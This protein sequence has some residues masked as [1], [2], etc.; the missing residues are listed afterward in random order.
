VRRERELLEKG[1]RDLEHRVSGAIERLSPQGNDH[2]S[3]HVIE[4][5]VRAA[6]GRAVSH[7]SAIEVR[8]HEGRVA[9]SG[10][11]LER[12]VRELMRRVSRVA[13]VRAIDNQLEPHATSE[14]VPALQG[15]GRVPPRHLLERDIWPPGW[16]LVAGAGG[17]GAA[18]YGL[19]RGRLKGA[20][21]M[22]GGGALLLRAVSNRPVA[23]AIGLS[24]GRRVVDIRKSIQVHAP[25]DEVFRFWTHVENFPRFMEHILEVQVNPE[26]ASRSH[27][28]VR[29]P[30]GVKMNW[31]AEVTR[32]EPNRIF[33]W[34]NLPGSSIEHAGIVHFEEVGPDTTRCHVQM[35][36]NPPVGVVGH[37]VASLLGADP[38][39]R[40]DEDLVRFK[41]L[42]EEGRTR[43]HGQRVTREE[44][45]RST[46]HS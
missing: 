37:A 12:E 3:D 30:G 5:R 2:V 28:V 44:L 8:S 41:A 16:R 45:E 10:P 7:P 18:L 34:K 13:G 40:M 36:Y 31:D 21:A 23:R 17:L 27:W 19:G 4:E 38:K 35:T 22:A 1:A 11:I 43:A 26:N 29:G 42:L 14:D 39:S 6:L 46:P 24:G 15:R 20:L 33:A 32:Y 9:L 25:I